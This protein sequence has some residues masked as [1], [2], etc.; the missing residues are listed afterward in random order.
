MRTISSNNN[1][2]AICGGALKLASIT[3]EERLGDRFYLFQNVPAQVCTVCSE[4]WIDE[5]VFQEIDR[6]IESGQPVRQVQT[7]VYDLALNH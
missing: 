7:P 6:L 2:C 4:I 5:A 1:H 3:H